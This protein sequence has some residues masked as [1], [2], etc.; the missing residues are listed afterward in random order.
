M[1][2]SIEVI[3]AQA[4]AYADIVKNTFKGVSISNFPIE[5]RNSKSS[6]LSLSHIQD[7]DTWPKKSTLVYID[8]A[9]NVKGVGLV[10]LGFVLSGKVSIHDRLRMIPGTPGK[11]A[12]VKGIQVNDEDQESTERGIRVGLSL[13][14]VELKDLEK[15]SWLDDGTLELSKKITFNFTQSKY[16][17]Q[18]TLNRDAHVQS[19]G[20]LIV[21]KISSSSETQGK[22]RGSPSCKRRYRCG[23]ACRFLFLISMESRSG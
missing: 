17:K 13:K 16:Y 15:V 6:V 1:K 3:D 20:D 19:N 21:A 22:E 11:F 23:K 18:D 8:R 5:E 10:V 12:E 2:G 9:F 14:G 4:S 7:R